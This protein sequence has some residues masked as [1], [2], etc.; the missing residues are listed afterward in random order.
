VL[1]PAL[2]A[3]ALV[4][5]T[6]GADRL[7]TDDGRPQQVICGKGVDLVTADARDRVASDCETVTRRVFVDPLRTSFGQ[8]ATAA[9]PDSAAAGS[10]VVSVFQVARRRGAGGAAAIGFATSHDGGST[11]RSGLLPGVRGAADAFVSDPTVVFDPVHRTWLAAS[12]F[13]RTGVGTGIL[14]SRSAD[15][16]TWTPPVTAVS[17]PLQDIAFDKEWLACDASLASAFRGRCYLAYTAVPTNTITLVASDDGGVTWTQP[18]GAAGA[19]TTDEL[20][21]VQPGVLPNGTVVMLFVEGGLRIRSAV[22]H[23]GGVTFPEVADVATAA[24]AFVPLRPGRLTLPSLEIGGDGR[25]HAV[26]ADARFGGG[27][28][29]V[30]WTSS[31]DGLTWTPPARIVA[32]AGGDAFLPALA[33]DPRSRRLA[34]T[35]YRVT[36]AGVDAFVVSSRNEG[37]TWTAPRRLSARTLALS[38]LARA[39]QPFLGDYTSTEFAGA[40]L[41]P[42]TILAAPPRNGLLQQGV[43]AASIVIPS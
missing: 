13:G 19:T 37:V 18:L 23:D 3:V 38:W 6:P 12:L 16:L 2:A 28:N 42:V 36:N 41:V 34:V 5:G 26:W 32:T 33:A 21:G 7:A 9:E 20:T 14:V 15:G 24:P 30:A 25:A 29:A 40:R 17:S 4:T 22:S 43:Y 11:W 35:S 10:T 39:P 1:A 8:H 31:A 27:D